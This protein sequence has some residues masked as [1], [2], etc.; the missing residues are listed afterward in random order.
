MTGLS[1]G[2]LDS[3]HSLHIHRYGRQDEFLVDGLAPV[4]TELQASGMVSRFFFLRYWQGGHH[5]RVRLRLPEYASEQVLGEVTARF[6]AYLT[7]CPGGGNLDARGPYQEAQ[8]TMAALEGER[9]MEIRPPD[10]VW[11][12]AYVPEHEKYGGECGVAIAEEFFHR[13]SEIVL[14]ALGAV[15]G[16]SAK[17]LGVAFSMMLRGLRAAGMSTMEMSEFFAH[18]CLFWAPYVFDQFL[19]TWSDLL[20]RRGRPMRSHAEAIV[21]AGDTL[22]DPFTAAVR[23]GWAAIGGAASEVL[24]AVTLAGMS[25]S[26]RRR[27][28]V[29]L[30]SYL[31]TH[32]NRLGLIPEEEAFLSYLGHHVLSECAGTAPRTD[33]LQTVRHHRDQRLAGR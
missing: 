28:E 8:Q 31:H 29:I 5:I 6:E 14:S 11:P 19:E 16:S 12:A 27:R 15:S 23:E 22:A 9:V 21:A 2:L 13:S 7:A 20:V 24:P 32:N 18:Y 25:A 17:R 30:V 10:S 3:W 1:P 26:A 4:L 33:F